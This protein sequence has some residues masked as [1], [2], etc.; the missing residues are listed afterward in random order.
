[1]ASNIKTKFLFILNQKYIKK[2]LKI[3]INHKIN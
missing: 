2:Y 1:M 3:K